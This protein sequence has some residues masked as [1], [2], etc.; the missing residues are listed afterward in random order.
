MFRQWICIGL[1]F[2]MCV[3]L[4]AQDDR[5]IRRDRPSSVSGRRVALVIGNADYKGSL[6]RLR[7]PANDARGMA[8]VLEEIGFEVIPLYNANRAEIGRAR[9]RV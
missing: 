5:A 3:P 6:T 4:W 8:Q 7:N 1:L 2:V 9:S